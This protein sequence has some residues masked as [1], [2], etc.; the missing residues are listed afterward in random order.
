MLER[1]IS[2]Y[3][4]RLFT[5]LLLFA[6]T[7]CGHLQ[8]SGSLAVTAAP[9]RL[10][11]I[12]RGAPVALDPAKRLLAFGRNG[13]R[14]LDRTTGSETLLSDAAPTALAWNPTGSRLA[15]AF[16]HGG[17]SR[18]ILYG[19]DGTEASKTD[20]PGSVCA[21]SWITG[22]DLLFA[23][24][25]TKP[26]SFGTDRREMLY[27]WNGSGTPIATL[28]GTTNV[29]PLTRSLFPWIVSSGL[30]LAVSPL[31]DEI[32]YARFFD[33]PAF[34]PYFRIIL[35]NL[36]TGQEREIASISL[37]GGRAIFVDAETVLYGNGV[38]ATYLVDPWESREI[39][40]FP[41][42]G[43]TLAV[44][45]RRI[46]LDDRLFENNV[47]IAVFPGGSILGFAADGS[48][49]LILHKDTVYLLDGLA[50]Q[51]RAPQLK[52]DSRQK[53]LQLRQWRSEGLITPG[54]YREMKERILTQ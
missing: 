4:G 24:L 36:A 2:R 16:G 28:L 20:V 30:Q 11:A 32:L 7:G 39:A 15:A 6:L 53:L 18:M 45:V 3:N 49:A 1:L 51:P 37:D 43:R 21:I 25:E 19:P 13:L 29:K 22:D 17:S 14:L 44:S 35:R 27:R 54:E 8:V 33:P 31:G 9:T 46:A 34:Q 52:P 48:G 38:E 42:P 40:S 50:E 5:G 12:D 26:F 10:A 47:E 23:A 41:L